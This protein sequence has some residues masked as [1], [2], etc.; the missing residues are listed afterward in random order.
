MAKGS[1]TYRIKVDGARPILAV[2]QHL[3]KD[4]SDE[5]RD[6]AERLAGTLARHAI[7]AGQAEGRQ[8]GIVSATVKVRRDRLP[9]ISAGGTKLIGRN[10]KPAFK[11]LFGSEFGARVLKQYKPHI[12][13]GSYWFFRTIEDHQAEISREWERVATAIVRKFGI[14]G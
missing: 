9:V 4:A 10:R 5:L 6:G 8:A 1:L 13:R 11:L 7:A 2:L 14:G 12:G 3:P